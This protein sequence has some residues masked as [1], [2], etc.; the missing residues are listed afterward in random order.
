MKEMI[1]K[2]ARFNKFRLYREANN[3]GGCDYGYPSDDDLN[4]NAYEEGKKL[5]KQ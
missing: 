1:Y 3:S 4:V 5:A 2:E